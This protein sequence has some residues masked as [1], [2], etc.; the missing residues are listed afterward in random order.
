MNL[1]LLKYMSMRVGDITVDALVDISK[2]LGYE[3]VGNDELVKTVVELLRKNDVDALSDVLSKPDVIEK[4]KAIV[5]T[6]QGGDDNLI[7]C[8]HCGEY[9]NPQ[10]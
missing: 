3:I 4:L 5:S 6:D 7:V 10:T 9:I 1:G 8:P 2:A